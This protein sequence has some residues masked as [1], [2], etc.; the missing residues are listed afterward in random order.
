[1][2]AAL[3]VRVD[4]GTTQYEKESIQFLFRLQLNDFCRLTLSEV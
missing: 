3:S 1:M 4:N 2:E